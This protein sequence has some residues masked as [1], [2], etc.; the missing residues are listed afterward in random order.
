MPVRTVGNIRIKHTTNTFRLDTSLAP[1][2]PCL[3]ELGDELRD[4]L[5]FSVPFDCKPK[6]YLIFTIRKR[7]ST[8]LRG[9]VMDA[10]NGKID[11]CDENHGD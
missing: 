10:V 6:G 4:I 3:E 2:R 1:C 8:R 5:G 9:L 7:L 11:F